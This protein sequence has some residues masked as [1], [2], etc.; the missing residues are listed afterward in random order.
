MT[1][2]W[3]DCGFKMTILLLLIFWWLVLVNA[4]DIC[5]SR[6]V[7]KQTDEFYLS[8]PYFKTID[9]SFENYKLI[10]AEIEEQVN[11]FKNIAVKYDTPSELDQLEPLPLIPFTDQNN[12]VKVTGLASDFM[13]ACRK[14]NTIPIDLTPATADKLTQILADQD[15]ESTPFLAYAVKNHLVSQ[16]GLVLKQ[17]PAD[18]DLKNKYN[19]FTFEGEIQTPVLTTTT[20]T[21]VTTESSTGTTTSVAASVKAEKNITGLCMKPNNFWDNGL[22]RDSW[23]PLITKIIKTLPSL[24][25]WRESI[26]NFLRKPALKTDSSRK[27]E[28]QIFKFSLPSGLNSILN[29]LKKYSSAQAWESSSASD[30][31]DFKNYIDNF[32][33]FIKMFKT[34]TKTIHK[35]STEISQAVLPSFSTDNNK[36]LRFLEID[37]NKNKIVGNIYMVSTT[38]TQDEQTVTIE[39]RFKLVDLQDKLTIFTVRPLIFRNSITTSKF[40]LQSHRKNLALIEEPRPTGC[41]QETF[42]NENIKVCQD[43]VTSGMEQLQPQTALACGNSLMLETEAEDFAKCLLTSPPSEPFAYKTNCKDYSLVISSATPLKIRVYCDT[44]LKDTIDL[45]RFPAY[46][47]TNCEIKILNGDVERILVPQLHSDF[48]QDSNS[49]V[50]MLLPPPLP[51]AN[52]SSFKMDSTILTLL[53]SLPIGLLSFISLLICILYLFDPERCKMA[54]KKICCCLNLAHCCRKPCSDCCVRYEY[55]PEYD[56]NTERRKNE[57][58]IR[59]RRARNEASQAI[60]SRQPSLLGSL[61]NVS[62]AASAPPPPED[63]EALLMRNMPRLMPSAKSSDN[64]NYNNSSRGQVDRLPRHSYKQ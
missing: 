10:L 23:F 14:H 1:I 21:T 33:S 61:G 42:N 43:Y 52:E 37:N 44:F 13:T 25:E 59:P 32:V 35:N 56:G 24:G 46:L 53:I 57:S 45:V 19:M 12:L 55:P 39:I 2:Y 22:N 15:L 4:G 8:Q 49:P 5:T 16:Q 26:S 27:E 3:K 28:R 9:A 34:T 7:L 60:Q 6:A 18:P 31:K 64:L 62:L 51:S 17:L 47:D 11:A 48:I 20:S 29:F 36:L 41:T 63:N 30:I 58:E 54:L 40:L 38:K 50:P